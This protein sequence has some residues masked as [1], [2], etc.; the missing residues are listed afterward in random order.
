[1]TTPRQKYSA[2]CRCGRVELAAEGPPIAHLSCYCDDCQAAAA[3][4]DA[5]PG[6]DSGIEADGGTPNILFRKDRV[7]CVAGAELL[8]PHRAREG[9]WTDRMVASCC[10]T[11]LMQVHHNWWPHRGVKAHLIE[12]ELPP[13][14]MRIFTKFAPDR[15]RVP[16]DV[17]CHA[18]IPARFGAR[19]V[20]TALAIRFNRA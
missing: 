3:L 16:T 15:R 1:M 18:T 17:P 5:L 6:G 20:R 19:L 4:I 2:R 8:E 9:T 12:G 13:L 11:A 10:N 7:R 14:E